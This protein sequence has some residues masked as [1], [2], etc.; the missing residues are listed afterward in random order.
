[1]AF[2]A[3]CGLRI[4]VYVSAMSEDA[5]RIYESAGTL[6]AAFDAACEKATKKWGHGNLTTGQTWVFTAV[7][8]HIG[9]EDDGG[10]DAQT[11]P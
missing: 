5:G 8:K 6:E 9:A 2:L 7:A 3:V 1:M 11:M 10:R 4:Q